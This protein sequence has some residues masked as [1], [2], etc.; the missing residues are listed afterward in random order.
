MVLI[1]QRCDISR[2]RHVLSLRASPG[3]KLSA[4]GKRFLLNK[5]TVQILHKQK[6]YKHFENTLVCSIVL[7]HQAY[8]VVTQMPPGSMAKLFKDIQKCQ[9]TRRAIDGHRRH[10]R[11]KLKITQTYEEIMCIYPNDCTQIH[12]V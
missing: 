8:P 5:N 9:T 3:V 2:S 6:I 4:Y 11:T 12:L 10:T 7:L 1:L